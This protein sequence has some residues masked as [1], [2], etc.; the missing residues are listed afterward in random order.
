MT[1]RTRLE[2]L[3]AKAEQQNYATLEQLVADDAPA[4]APT[5]IAPKLRGYRGNA[6][7]PISQLK[8]F[9]HE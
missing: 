3:E 1:L 7:I 4:A 6:D 2:R 5:G 9:R 8:E